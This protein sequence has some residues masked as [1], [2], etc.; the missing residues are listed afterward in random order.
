[1]SY[2]PD[3]WQQTHWDWRAAANFVCGG[4]G[5]GLGVFAALSGAGMPALAA[6]IVI[7]LAAIGCGL[8]CVWLEIGRPLRALNVFLNPFT[9][10]MTREAFAA[11]LLFPVGLAAA[12]GFA[13]FGW[14]AAAL[15]L[16]FLYCQGRIL[17]ASKGIPA[18]REP[19]VLPLILITGLTEGA[20]LFFLAGPLHGQGTRSL[21]ILFGALVAGRALVWRS[22]RRRIGANGAPRALDALDGAGGQLRLAGTLLPLVL[23]VVAV[24][25]DV[26]G[27]AG[28]VIAAVA[29][30]A[31]T[32]AGAAMKFTLVT[33]AAFNQGFALKHLPVR[34]VRP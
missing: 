11:T 5:S 23:I 4:A 29:G 20:G 9:S 30:L 7:G 16:A 1:M 28:A 24:A 34:G 3:P 14:L 10:W 8:T 18:W 13:G 22:Y 19:M 32:A 2:G 6:L 17:M 33:R 25:V 21:L 31:A 26:G 15:A 12:F 27:T